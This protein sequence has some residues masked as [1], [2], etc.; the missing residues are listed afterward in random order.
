VLGKSKG[1]QELC[2][3]CPNNCDQVW[4]TIE[5]FIIYMLMMIMLLIVLILLANSF[6]LCRRHGRR[7]IRKSFVLL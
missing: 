7:K 6:N 1:N 3:G 4:Y 2:F 5:K